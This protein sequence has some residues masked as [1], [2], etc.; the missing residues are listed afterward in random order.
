[1]EDYLF[2]HYVDQC[3]VVKEETS[4]IQ[5]F[6]YSDPFYDVCEE[7]PLPDDEFDNFLHQ[8]DSI[9]KDRVP[10]RRQII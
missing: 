9:D 7:H 3:R 6:N 4:Y 5:V 10:L 8:R 1:M 2:R